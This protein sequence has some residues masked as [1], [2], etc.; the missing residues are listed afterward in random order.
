[1]V[2]QSPRA[3]RLSHA[4]DRVA[5][6]AAYRAHVIEDGHAV[7]AE[8][9]LPEAEWQRLLDV[10]LALDTQLRLDPSQPTELDHG[11]AD[12]AGVKG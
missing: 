3:T 5:R 9:H 6:D 4:I 1:M 12:A 11:E 7:Q 10:A 8:A 2:R